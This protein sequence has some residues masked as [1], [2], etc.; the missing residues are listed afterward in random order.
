VIFIPM[1]GDDLVDDFLPDD[2]VALSD[3]EHDPETD[4]EEQNASANP[5]A[6]S[7]VS[8]T[9][10]A[11]RKRRLKERERKAKK[12]KL[13]DPSYTDES[14][15]LI[16]TNT[17]DMVHDYISKAQATALPHLSSIE[18][19]D[20]RIPPECIAD[21]TAWSGP[22]TI[23]L[24]PE[25]IAKTL[26]TLKTRLGQRPKNF[27]APTLI[28]IAAAALRVADVTRT[29]KRMKDESGSTKAGDIAKLFAK[30]FKLEEHARYLKKTRV[31][32]AVGTPGRIG[33]LLLET[34]SLSTSAL[35]HIVIDTTF[36]DSKKRSI[37]DIPETKEELFRTVLGATAVRKALA[38]G[39][40]TIVLF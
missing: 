36:R 17:P 25:F 20:W 13:A 32:A 40:V 19:D 28:F 30:H 26:P 2:I 10:A 15:A 4:P 5:P 18:L 31:G 9:T 34:D 21:T 7:A 39:T 8:A 1:A 33:K 29:L 16:S 14:L 11:K 24:L 35:S 27:G 12:R 38:C 23:E 22:R 6:T 37:F 3:G